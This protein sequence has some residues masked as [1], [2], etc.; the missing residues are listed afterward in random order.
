MIRP[1]YLQK[2]DTVAIVSPAKKIAPEEIEIAIDFLE[3]HGLTVLLGPNVFNSWNRF[4]G[5]DSRKNK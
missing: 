4:S 5:S 3:Q 1:P 2:G